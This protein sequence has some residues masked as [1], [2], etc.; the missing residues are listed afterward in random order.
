MTSK[1]NV[2][3]E[4]ESPL[5][6][7]EKTIFNKNIE[8]ERNDANLLFL[9]RFIPDDKNA[10]ILDAGCGNGKYASYLWKLG[11]HNL[12]AIDLYDRIIFKEIP[13]QKASIDALPF[14]DNEFDFI[15]CNSVIYH[16]QKPEKGLS[17]FQRVLRPGGIL[18]FTG[19]T[20]YSLH[21]L[22]RR[23]KIIMKNK[24]VENL[25][26]A[27]FYSTKKYISIL[28][29]NQFKIIHLDGFDTG[30]FLYPYYR[31]KIKWFEI[32]F[33]IKLP[34]IKSC[35]SKIKTIGRLKASFLY[36]FVIICQKEI[37]ENFKN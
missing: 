3:N 5:D 12:V 24:S 10:R 20:K 4:K 26:N 18:L 33:K 22:W 2:N 34:L 23:L 37:I 31:R 9:T 17:E 6:F 30:L 36:H 16:L 25:K 21:T 7:Y 32:H 15:Y 8:I 13:Y 1:N 19:H 35:I 14:A 11:Y 28:K 29:H 27:T